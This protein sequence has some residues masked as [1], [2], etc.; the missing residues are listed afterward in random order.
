MWDLVLFPQAGQ[1]PLLGPHSPWTSPPIPNFSVPHYCPSPI[2]QLPPQP[3]PPLGAW[4][5]G[6][7]DAQDYLLSEQEKEWTLGS[8]VVA[9]GAGW[10]RRW[11]EVGPLPPLAPTRSPSPE[12]LGPSEAAQGASRQQRPDCRER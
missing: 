11:R 10:R 6:T 1:A 8:E 5:Q 9:K 2:S 3:G 7:W 4:A 12:Q